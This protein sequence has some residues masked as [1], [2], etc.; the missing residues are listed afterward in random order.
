MSH[1]HDT[2]TNISTFFGI[3][4]QPETVKFPEWSSIN[5]G[6]RGVYVL[7]DRAAELPG[8]EYIYVG[9]GFFRARQKSHWVKANDIVPVGHID[10]KGWKWLR[11]NTDMA[12]DNW[13]LYVIDLARETELSAM[14]GSLIHLLQPLAN[15]ET[16]T[17]RKNL[18]T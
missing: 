8:A 9:K 2:I 11:A 1:L 17:D 3:N 10:P 5:R 4:I 14:E 16:F 13:H 12:V 15:D 7:V 6:R 18:L